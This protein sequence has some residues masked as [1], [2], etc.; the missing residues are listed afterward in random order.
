MQLAEAKETLIKEMTLTIPVKE[1]TAEVVQN[2]TDV[3]KSSTGNI[4]FRVKVV[5]PE[6]EIS[7]GLYSRTFR[8][9]LSSEL[10]RFC[11]QGEYKFSLI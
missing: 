3:V 5:D 9:N 10:I 11:E 2:L 8:I 6:N 7:L 1:I 4:L